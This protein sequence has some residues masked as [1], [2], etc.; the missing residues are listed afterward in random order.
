MYSLTYH[1][2]ESLYLKLQ[3]IMVQIYSFNLLIRIT[4]LSSSIMSGVDTIVYEVLPCQC[5]Y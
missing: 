1:I 4:G 3:S 2:I 5:A